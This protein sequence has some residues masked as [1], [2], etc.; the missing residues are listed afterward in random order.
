MSYVNGQCL[1]GPGGLVS[2]AVEPQQRPEQDD[3]DKG[4]A[5]LGFRIA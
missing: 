3:R 2:N 5:D 1:I 4:A